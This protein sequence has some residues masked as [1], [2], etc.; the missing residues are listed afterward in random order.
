MRWWTADWHLGH[1]RILDYCRRPFVTIEDHDEALEWEYREV[2]GPDDEVMF[3]GDVVMG[4]EPTRMRG[5]ERLAALPGRKLLVPGNHD[6]VHPMHQAKLE[7]WVPRYVDAGLTIVGSPG[8]TMIAGTSGRLSTVSHFPFLP[9]GGGTVPPDRD[10]AAWQPQD[11]GRDWLIHGHV[12]DGWRVRDRQI[13]VGVD[14]W[15]YRMVPESAVAAI[16]RRTDR[17]AVV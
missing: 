16:I 6:H 2:V 4:D 10:F 8:R 9:A 13:N 14:A 5:L 17:P 3:L 11:R 7:L 12:H 1:D 15:G